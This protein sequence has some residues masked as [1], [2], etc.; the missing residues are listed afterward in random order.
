MES[1]T[2][3]KT[4]A[5]WRG[6]ILF[7]KGFFSRSS[8][9]FVSFPMQTVNFKMKWTRIQQFSPIIFDVFIFFIFSSVFVFVHFLRF[10]FYFIFWCYICDLGIFNFLLLFSLKRVFLF[11]LRCK[12]VLLKKSRIQ[13]ESLSTLMG[14]NTLGWNNIKL[15]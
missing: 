9:F 11:G 7:A 13:K 3:C 8:F 2:W 6:S 5:L 4:F 10:F 1:R 14:Y 15:V 12:S